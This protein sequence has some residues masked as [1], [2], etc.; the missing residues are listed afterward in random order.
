MDTLY[1]ESASSE[2]SMLE[3]PNQGPDSDSESEKDPNKLK[4]KGCKK[5][6]LRLDEGILKPLLVYKYKRYTVK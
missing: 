6:L 2:R 5:Y 1:D 3:H 4:S